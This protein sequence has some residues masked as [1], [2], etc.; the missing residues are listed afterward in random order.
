MLPQAQD[1]A[2]GSFVPSNPSIVGCPPRG[3]VALSLACEQFWGRAVQASCDSLDLGR[4][5]FVVQVPKELQVSTSGRLR[6]RT[7]AC[8]QRTTFP[9][10]LR[11]S[12]LLHFFPTT[13]CGRRRPE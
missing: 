5:L 13:S 9:G 7:C 11:T 4:F 10:R 8:K 1:L 2:S 12:A 3:W 6:L